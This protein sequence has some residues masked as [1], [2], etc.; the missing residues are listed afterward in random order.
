[1]SRGAV[2]VAVVLAFSIASGCSTT[3]REPDS[4]RSADL[5]P[6]EFRAEHPPYGS[7]VVEPIQDRRPAYELGS[8]NYLNESYYSE[9]LFRRPVVGVVRSV[10][11]RALVTSGLF[12]PPPTT[13]EAAYALRVSL[14]HFYAKSDRDLLGLIPFFPTIDVEGR[15]VV[16]MLLTDP[17]GRRFLERRYDVKETAGTATIGNVPGTGADLL[18]EALSDLLERFLA[19]AD[20]GV[21]DFWRGLDRD[22][23][24]PKIPR[25]ETIPLEDEG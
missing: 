12:S 8:E 16:E 23:F 1:M 5:P 14:R 18:L 6:L 17:D 2:V 7:V 9:E 4:P 13:G 22:P 15:I 3:P 24:D 21:E 19:D 20:R 25:P 11:G 10:F